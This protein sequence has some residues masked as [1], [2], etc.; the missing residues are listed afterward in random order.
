MKNIRKYLK[1]ISVLLVFSSCNVSENHQS[2]HAC[3]IN[4]NSAYEKHHSGVY[5]Q[6]LEFNSSTGFFYSD[7]SLVITY[8]EFDIDLQNSIT[9]NRNNIEELDKMKLNSKQLDVV[10]LS[11][12]SL[13]NLEITD[14]IYHIND[15]F[16][17]SNRSR[18]ECW[19]LSV[20]V[21]YEPSAPHLSIN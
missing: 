21:N 17:A 18:L 14:L 1:S 16:T 20:I 4:H 2:I 13:D 3:L 19:K 6:E 10:V 12:R 9:I 15:V 8:S 11:Y 7:E 5:Y